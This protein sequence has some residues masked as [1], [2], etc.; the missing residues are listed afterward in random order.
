M[1]RPEKYERWEIRS[2]RPSPSIRVF[3]R[4]AEP[5]VFVATHAVERKTLR[6]K[7]DMAWDINLVQCEQSWQEIFGS[8]LPFLGAAFEDYITTNATRQMGLKR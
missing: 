7:G 8:L 2:V 5:D 4:F 6:A 3:G 1:A